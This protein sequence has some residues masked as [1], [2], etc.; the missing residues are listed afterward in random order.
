MTALVPLRH[1]VPQRDE[2]TPRPR[3]GARAAEGPWH[4][5]GPAHARTPAALRS[6]IARRSGFGRPLP[7]GGANSRFPL[8]L[9][10]MSLPFRARFVAPGR[11][12]DQPAARALSAM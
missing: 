12:S 11:E 5:S 9:A 4:R 10:S 7:H 2:R 1:E 6:G 8:H 3:R